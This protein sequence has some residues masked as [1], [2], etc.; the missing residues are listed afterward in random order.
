MAPFIP[1]MSA[2]WGTRV[3]VAYLRGGGGVDPPLPVSYSPL[4][5]DIVMSKLTTPP[6]KEI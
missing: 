4:I 2:D 6:L 5:Y 1:E 3:P